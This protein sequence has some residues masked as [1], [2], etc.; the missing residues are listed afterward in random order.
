VR[1]TK[2]PGITLKGGEG[3]GV[4]TRPGLG[5]PVGEPAINPVPRRQIRENV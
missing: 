4:V 2:T 5:L 1:L 3:V